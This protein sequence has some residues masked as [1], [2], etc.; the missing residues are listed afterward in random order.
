[1]ALQQVDVYGDCFLN[2]VKLI[3][4]KYSL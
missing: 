3:L 1:L 4:F 2:N